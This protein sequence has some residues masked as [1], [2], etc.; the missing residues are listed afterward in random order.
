MIHELEK[1]N[2]VLKFT[3]LKTDKKKNANMQQMPR[4]LKYN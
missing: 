1:V 3:I 4:R 2:K